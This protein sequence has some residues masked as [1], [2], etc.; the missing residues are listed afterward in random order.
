MAVGAA[1]AVLMAGCATQPGVGSAAYSTNNIPEPLLQAVH[2]VTNKYAPDGHVVVCRIAALREGSHFVLKG[3]V[4]NP[5]AKADA[6]AAAARTGLDVRDRI[7]LLPAKSLRDRLWGITTLSVVNVREQANNAAEMGTQMLTGEAFKV[8]KVQTNW[9]LVQTA[10]RYVGWAEGGGFTNCT[11]AEVEAWNAA[12]RLLVTAYDERIV[13]QPEAG[14][15]T[16]S[17]VVMGSQV[18][19]VGEAGD[20]FQVELADGR[21]GYLPKKS[22]VEYTAW[23]ASRQPTAQNIER[24]AREFLGRPYSWGGNSIR[25]MDCSGFTK[26]VYFLNGID[27]SRNASEQCRQGVEVPLSDDLKNLKKGDLLF[28]G[29]RALGGKPEW[30]NHAGIYLGDKLFIQAWERVQIS[31][32]DSDSPLADRKRIRG[33][34]HAR[35]IL[36]QN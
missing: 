32:L 21:G 36:D 9:Y 3:D 6:L 7:D 28:F 4:E 20:W 31:S 5:A 35:R 19:R 1:T 17:D 24:T 25:G 29:R 30:V 12:P 2:S 23:K 22:A 16:V 11:R 15:A 8:W 33:L 13:E 14:A 34:L 27:L 26:F 10:D 18:K